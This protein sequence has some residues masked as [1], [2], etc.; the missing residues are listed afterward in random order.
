[1]KMK[2][3]VAASFSALLI[4]AAGSSAALACT[5][6]ELTKKVNEVTTAVQEAVT[7]DPSKAQGIITKS[8][9]M[10]TK[11]QGSTDIN[12]ACKAY[13]ELLEFVKK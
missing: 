3:L 8:Q 7:K 11:F 6:E 10:Q 12:E 13:D 1:M 4:T 2:T 9:E 5:Q